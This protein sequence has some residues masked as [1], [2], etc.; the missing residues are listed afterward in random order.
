MAGTDSEYTLTFS[1]L[2]GDSLYLHDLDN[3]SI[4][5]MLENEQYHFTAIPNSINNSRFQL[6]LNPQLSSKDDNTTTNIENTHNAIKI[7]SKGKMV[8]ILN[9]PE[10]S[11]AMVYSVSGHHILSTP[12]NNHPSLAT[13][14]LCQLPKGVYIIRLNNLM[15]K[16]VCK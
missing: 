9:A 13:I 16:F 3:D 2:I 1:S 15:Y 14:D 12:I 10:N 11:V 8:Y 5:H 6:L 4:I 7:W